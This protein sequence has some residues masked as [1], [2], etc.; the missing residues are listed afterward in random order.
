M[1]LFLLVSP[2]TMAMREGLMPND[3]ARNLMQA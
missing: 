1:V 2:L 3:F